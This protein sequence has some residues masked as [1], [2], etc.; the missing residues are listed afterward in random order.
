[1]KLLCITGMPCAGKTTTIKFLSSKFSVVSMGDAIRKE[2][3]EKNMDRDMREYSTEFRKK[4]K[5]YAAKICMPEIEKIKNA[6]ICIVDGIRNYEEVEEF[7]KFYDVVLIAIYASPK[8]RYERFTKRKRP[9]DNLTYKG[10]INRDIA[11]LIWGLGNVIAL[12]D[13][14][15]SN[16]DGNVKKFKENLI[17]EISKIEKL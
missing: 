2:M 11:E 8:K 6:E 4:D 3:K 16:E 15:I 10:F 12:S 13:L 1:M 9:D 14:I 7:R 17:S 5:G